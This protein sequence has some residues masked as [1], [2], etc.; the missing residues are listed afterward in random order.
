LDKPRAMRIGVAIFRHLLALGSTAALGAVYAGGLY[1]ELFAMELGMNKDLGG[2]LALILMSLCGLVWGL[3]YGVLVCLPLAAV[4]EFLLRR[5][6]PRV[7]GFV[8]CMVALAA[9]LMIGLLVIPV[10]CTLGW[11]DDGHTLSPYLDA[12]ATFLLALV[13]LAAPPL[14]Y[15]SV[16]RGLAWVLMVLARRFSRLAPFVVRPEWV[17]PRPA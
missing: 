14:A 4:G 17:E 6:P 11:P 3:A 16:L 9:L 15:W 10:M 13:P 7:L 2:P 8:G 12:P 1:L 5:K